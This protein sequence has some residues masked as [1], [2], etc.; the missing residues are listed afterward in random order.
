M[1]LKNILKL[2][3]RKYNIWRRS[4]SQSH[5]NTESET[6]KQD[7]KLTVIRVL[8]VLPMDLMVKF[9]VLIVMEM[10]RVHRRINKFGNFG[11]LFSI[12]KRKP[13]KDY[14]VVKIKLY[15]YNR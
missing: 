10:T 14:C 1:I 5:A 2:C 12:L 11:F 7:E 6:K 8:N 3:F 13:F 4:K 15:N 9:N